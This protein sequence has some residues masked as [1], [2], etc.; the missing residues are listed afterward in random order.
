MLSAASPNLEH[1]NL[2][3]LLYSVV[4]TLG[5]CRYYVLYVIAAVSVS[6][7]SV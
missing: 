1:R 4:A 2:L 6:D 3:E 5:K 7:N